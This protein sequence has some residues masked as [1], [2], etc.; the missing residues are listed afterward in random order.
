VVSSDPAHSTFGVSNAVPQYTKVGFQ[1]GELA[2]DFALHA[3]DSRSLRLSDLRG[4]PVLLKFW[5]TWCA[6]CR[7]EMPWLVELDEKYRTQG[8]QIIG[9]SMNDAGAVKEVGSFAVE[10]GVKYELLLGNSATAAAYGGVRFMPQ[11]FFID[12]ERKIT[13]VTTGLTDKKD[14]EDGVKTLLT[15]HGDSQLAQGSQR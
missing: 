15:N 4:H 14:F 10:R 13:K 11:T 1:V 8:L 2:P 12:S 3:L 6:P 5:A 9:V 7:V